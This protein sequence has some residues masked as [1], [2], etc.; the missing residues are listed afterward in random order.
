MD[1]IDRMSR[2]V[3]RDEAPMALILPIPLILRIL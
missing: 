1:R 2:M 3:G